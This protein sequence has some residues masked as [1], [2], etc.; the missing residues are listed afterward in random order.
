[1]IVHFLIS[2]YTEWVPIP[3]DVIVTDEDR[4]AGL[5]KAMI[6]GEER[7]KVVKAAHIKNEK[8]ENA[9][10]FEVRVPETAIA[11]RMATRY[12]VGKPMSR[13]QVAAEL[14]Q[15]QLV[16]HIEEHHIENV[17]VHDDGPDVMLMAQILVNISA[18]ADRSDERYK[19]AGRPDKAP[20]MSP[21]LKEQLMA[22]YTA[23]RDL[24]QFFKATYA[25]AAPVAPAKG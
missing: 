6:N 25:P 2:H 16:L 4:T 20:R 15:G 21:K 3:A 19:A 13:T 9:H 14:V 7:M 22:A 1:M 18:E 10:Y 17:E 8:G 23:G 24:T 12:L 11:M 5:V